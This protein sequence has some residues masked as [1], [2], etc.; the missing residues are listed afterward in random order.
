MNRKCSRTAS[1]SSSEIAAWAAA[2]QR[3]H[4]HVE[5]ALDA[6]VDIRSDGRISLGQH[7]NELVSVYNPRH[8]SPQ[9]ILG[10]SLTVQPAG[11]LERVDTS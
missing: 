8:D 4:L 2:C 6:F 11:L 7:G 5:E 1:L 9:D 10:Q 3:P